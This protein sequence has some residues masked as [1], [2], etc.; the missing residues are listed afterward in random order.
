M[1]REVSTESVVGL[2]W[3]RAADRLRGAGSYSM[4][5]ALARP[6]IPG[7][8]WVRALENDER[9][10]SPTARERVRGAREQWPF[11]GLVFGAVTLLAELAH[12]S[13]VEWGLIWRLTRPVGCSMGKA[14]TLEA[15]HG[16]KYRVV[17]YSGLHLVKGSC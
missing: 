8:L 1:M 2:R 14:R 15:A 5:Y 6:N 11:K 12:V 13:E 3:L 16:S 7:T 4:A 17:E 9:S 10:L